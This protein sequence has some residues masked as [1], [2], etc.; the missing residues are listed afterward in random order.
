M[1][2]ISLV[3]SDLQHPTWDSPGEEISSHRKG[4]HMLDSHKL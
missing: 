4:F 1:F 2:P 3:E